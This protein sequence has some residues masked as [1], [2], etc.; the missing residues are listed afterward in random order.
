[1]NCEDVDAY[2]THGLWVVSFATLEVLRTARN[3]RR[4]VYSNENFT[5]ADELRAHVTTMG[6]QVEAV[7]AVEAVGVSPSVWKGVIKNVPGSL[8]NAFP[9][10]YDSEVSRAQAI[11]STHV[12]AVSIRLPSSPVAVPPTASPP[13]LHSL[14]GPVLV[15]QGLRY[16]GNVGAILRTAVQANMFSEVVVIDPV[17]E[18][19]AKNN[20]RIPDSDVYYYR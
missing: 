2:D 1:M 15:L 4:V 5:A 12:V 20:D 17:Y 19:G 6:A 13:T 7:E 10:D 11:G 18:E 14:P 16:R 8:V 3:L 9:G